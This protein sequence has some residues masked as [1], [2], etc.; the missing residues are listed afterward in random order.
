MAYASRRLPTEELVKD[1]VGE[2]MTRA[3]ACIDRFRAEGG[4]LDAWM[5]G[6][7]R[8]V[9]VDMQRTMWREGPGLVPDA[10]DVVEPQPEE[11]SLRRD[12]TLAVRSAFARL[13]SSDQELLELRVVAG[14]SAEE[15]G[16]VLGRRPG[17]VRMAQSRALERLRSHLSRLGADDGI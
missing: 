12:D 7:A 10:T 15:V 17:A 4:G 5:Y 11:P 9:V 1:A 13:S 6:I 8:H 2:T 16:Y 3:I 14:L